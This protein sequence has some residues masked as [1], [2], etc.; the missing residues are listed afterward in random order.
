MEA[1]R[2]STFF[3]G[4]RENPVKR[5][6]AGMA[7]ALLIGFVPAAVYAI[8]IN[9]AEVRWIRARQRELSGQVGTEPILREFER[10]D[11]AVPAIRRRG[12]RHTALIWVLVTGIAAAGWYRLVERPARDAANGA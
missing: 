6:F 2:P 12:I 8:G 4:L 9:G 11:A 3:G 7:L 1:A 10:L 5:A